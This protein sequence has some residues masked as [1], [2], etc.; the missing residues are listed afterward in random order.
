MR[1][2]CLE[3]VFRHIEHLRRR[4]LDYSQ[5]PAHRNSWAFSKM[6]RRRLD[7]RCPIARRR[8]LPSKWA[9]WVEEV[10][11]RIKL[12]VGPPVVAAVPLLRHR[13]IQVRRRRLGHRRRGPR[14]LIPPEARKCSSHGKGRSRLLAEKRQGQYVNCGDGRALRAAKFSQG[15]RWLLCSICVLIPCGLALRAL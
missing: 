3:Q 8:C 6:W 15:P 2:P 11:P 4:C 12:Q 9:P 10:R 7:R 5:I 1:S 13:R 14:W